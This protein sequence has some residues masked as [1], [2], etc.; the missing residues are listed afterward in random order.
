[1]AKQLVDLNIK[2]VFRRCSTLGVRSVRSSGRVGEKTDKLVIK[3]G[4]EVSVSVLNG[5]KRGR[6]W[7][8]GSEGERKWCE[9][10]NLRQCRCV[11]GN[12]WPCGAPR[13]SCRVPRLHFAFRFQ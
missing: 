13:A 8:W 12:S 11:G 6:R 4:A 10:P 7:G 3:C 2:E 9:L 1:M 5:R